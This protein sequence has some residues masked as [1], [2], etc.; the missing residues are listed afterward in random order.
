MGAE[1]D[2]VHREPV[3]SCPTTPARG[4]EVELLHR[5]LELVPQSPD[6]QGPER[7]EVPA[8]N[9]EEDE[10]QPSVAFVMPLNRNE[11]T[12]MTAETVERTSWLQNPHRPRRLHAFA[13][14]CTFFEMFAVDSS[15]SPFFARGRTTRR[16]R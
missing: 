1:A 14:R 13:V 7:G 15:T 10:V 2:E 4:D 12:R 3:E 11:K 16:R 5:G 9:P 6:A 8:H